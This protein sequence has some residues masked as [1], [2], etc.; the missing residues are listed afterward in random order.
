LLALER[1]RIAIIIPALNEAGTIVAIVS[2]A[3]R[4]GVPIVVDDGSRDGTGARAAAAG[5]E[6]V[7]HASNRGYD[8]AINSGFAHASTLGCEYVLTVDADGQH[9]PEI[10]ESFVRALDDGADVVVGI[11][12][13][14]AR[15]AESVFAWVTAIRWGIRDPL[16]GVKAYRIDVWRELGHFDSYESIGTELT[17]FAAANRKQL[18]QLSVK[19]GDRQ[20]ATRFGGGFSANWR[21][22]RALWIGMVV[23]AGV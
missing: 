13:R 22:F 15:L 5:A 19:V 3:A 9:E 6:V 14:R 1:H 23:G 12:D 2:G 10:L 17:I 4:Y 21:I 7:T 16:C 20:G 8:Q 18:A 11:R